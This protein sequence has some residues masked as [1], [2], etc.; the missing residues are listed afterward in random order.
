M[1]RSTA[2][3]RFVM[4]H[5]RNANQQAYALLSYATVAASSQGR[6]I[7]RW[8]MNIKLCYVTA[9]DRGR[10]HR[11]AQT[12]AAAVVVWPPPPTA[13]LSK[14]GETLTEPQYTSHTK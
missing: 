3:P 6:A 2:P 7:T 11:P 14:A 4:T 13:P 12:M 1:R 9:Q 5:G 10:S 8:V